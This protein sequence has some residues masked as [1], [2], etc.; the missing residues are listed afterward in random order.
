MFPKFQNSN[1]NTLIFIALC[2]VSSFA[3]SA[4]KKDPVV[5]DIPEIPEIEKKIL[6]FQ[7][8]F[9]EVVVNHAKKQI[10]IY[11]TELPGMVTPTIQVADGIVL[12]PLSGQSFHESMPPSYTLT[13]P[14]GSSVTYKVIVCTVDWQFMEVFG[15]GFSITGMGHF[16]EPWTATSQNG[17]VHIH[18]GKNNDNAIDLFVNCP[19]APA[20][21]GTFPV[22]AYAVNSIPLGKASAVFSFRENGVEKTYGTPLGG[23]VQITYYDPLLAT[24]SGTFSQVKYY[25]TPGQTQGHPYFLV[26]GSFENLPLEQNN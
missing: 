11:E 1:F 4:C 24:I 10:V 21:A 9:T 8:P 7:I 5:V 25:E 12:E 26:S 23:T 15:S 17:V 20:S 18:F 22:G 6:D 16:K 19:V 3:F 13:A 14:D 2:I